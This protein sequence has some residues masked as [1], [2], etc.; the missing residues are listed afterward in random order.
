VL[1]KVLISL[2]DGAGKTENITLSNAIVVSE[3]VGRPP[4]GAGESQVETLY[5][6][7]TK[8]ELAT[9]K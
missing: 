2:P 7:F 8:I 4:T 6:N 5:L 3:I 1:S 9:S